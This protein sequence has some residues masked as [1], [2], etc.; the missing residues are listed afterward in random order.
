[1]ELELLQTLGKLPCGEV[2]AQEVS[3]WHVAT[4][5]EASGEHKPWKP[6]GKAVPS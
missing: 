5:Q 4:D 6:G 2:R 1:M 3:S